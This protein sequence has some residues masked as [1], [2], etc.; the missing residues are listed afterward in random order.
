MKSK[1][2]IIAD[3]EIDLDAKTIIATTIIP[4]D[5]KD[6][7]KRS[8]SRTN[9]FKV[10]K[11][12]SNLVNLGYLD[13]E[14]SQSLIPYTKLFAIYYENG[15][16]KISGYAY[17]KQVNSAIE[18]A[19]F[20]D[21]KDFFDQLKLH[22]V[23]ELD[24]LNPAAWSAANIDSWRMNTTQICVPAV[25]YGKMTA[26]N[27]ETGFYLPSMFYYEM[28]KKCFEFFGLT[29]IGDILN[30]NYFKMLCI[31]YSYDKWLY[32]QKFIDEHSFVATAT[33]GTIPS[34]AAAAVISAAW[35]FDGDGSTP[36]F[37]N[38]GISKIYIPAAYGSS[39]D[40]VQMD[41][42]VRF[43]FEANSFTGDGGKFE[44]IRNRA[45][46]T[47]LAVHNFTMP[48]APATNGDVQL[49]AL[50]VDA[51]NNDEYYLKYTP[52]TG[53]PLVQL[54]DY[55]YEVVNTGKIF[56]AWVFFNYLL[57]ELNMFDLIRD[58]FL[59][60][61]II[62]KKVGNTVYLKTIDEIIKDRKN[63]V[64]WSSKRVPRRDDNIDFSFGYSKENYF[65]PEDNIES[66]LGVGSISIN[67]QN[68]S[69]EQEL[70][71]SPF[72][73]STYWTYLYATMALIPVFDS[74]SVDIEDFKEAPGLRLL[75]QRA[76]QNP[77][78]AIGFGGSTELNY[79]IGMF[80][81]PNETIHA[82]FQYTLDTYYDRL[83]KSLQKIKAITRY[84]NFEDIDIET[85]D[86][87]KLIYDD[88]FYI[89]LKIADH[90]SDQPT[91]VDL[92]KVN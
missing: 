69:E 82:G 33:P 14:H 19:I 44:L 54:S 40:F 76:R 29:P 12:H 7:T 77:E 63:A 15:F 65:S 87:H 23:T 5:V 11:T 58:F 8:V 55:S 57:P 20:E 28:V 79:R 53:T 74:T 45:G 84:Y 42:R 50:L 17:I 89:V 43:H 70:Y 10:P 67:N 21:L 62:D 90:R 31:P 88:G 26:S 25:N 92:L 56:T 52:V 91:K 49:E 32:P 6:L 71:S 18:I 66:D 75:Y 86:K 34:Y 81:Q 3:K 80:E 73:N 39:S 83:G 72:G 78:Q 46:E 60:F 64:D 24:Y 2:L 59:R 61:G 1:R 68:L 41:I 16:Q 37:F 48:G 4:F 27:I 13:N 85:F 9:M 38:T 51:R 36:D 35:T 47:V 30:E 22:S